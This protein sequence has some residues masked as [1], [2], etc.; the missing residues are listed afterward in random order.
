[1]G[2]STERCAVCGDQDTA[3]PESRPPA[4]ASADH[5]GTARGAHLSRVIIEGRALLMCRAHAATVVAA[6]P[7]TF[8][9]LRA[10][11]IGAAPCLDPALLLDPIPGGVADDPRCPPLERRSPIPR[12]GFEDRRVFP[13]RPEGRRRGGG[14]RATDPID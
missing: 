14:R 7:E 8:E 2:E 10:L 4:H 13:P 1:M 6:M 12:R 11:F 3:G 9:D 5:R